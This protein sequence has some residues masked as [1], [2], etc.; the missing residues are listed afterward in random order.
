MTESEIK[1]I[2]KEAVKEGVQ[3]T[4]LGLG[5]D[6]EDPTEIQ[7][8]WAF[9]TNWR[10]NSEAVKQQGLVAIVIAVL[11]GL[12]GLVWTVLKG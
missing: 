5:M 12:L 11:V 7:K 9:L 3:E 8:N 1:A 2:V 10:K 4:L 6:M